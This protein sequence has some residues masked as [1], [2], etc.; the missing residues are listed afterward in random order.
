MPDTKIGGMDVIK[1]VFGTYP[2]L[3]VIRLAVF[4]MFWPILRKLGYG[5]TLNQLI[6]CS[7][8]GLRGA[9]GMSLALMVCVDHA[10]PAVIQDIILLHISGIALMTLLINATTTGWLVNKLGLSKQSD[11]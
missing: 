11:L 8:A 6:L 9:V 4:F 3:H 7:Y 10:I 1:L 2:I 5:L